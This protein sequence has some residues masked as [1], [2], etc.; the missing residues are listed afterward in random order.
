[1]FH[2]SHIGIS[3]IH[4]RERS[5]INISNPFFFSL[6]RTGSLLERISDVVVRTEIA[7]G[8]RVK[9]RERLLAGGICDSS[10]RGI[11]C[12]VPME[13]IFQYLHC[14]QLHHLLEI[15]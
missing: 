3:D 13:C 8:G 5:Q 12:S 1:V 11:V 14:E 15:E 9:R 4:M 6:T 2:V 7:V 10:S